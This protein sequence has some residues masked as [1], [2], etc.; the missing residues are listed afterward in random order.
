MHRK[1]IKI[2]SGGVHNICIVE[3]HPCS[4]VEEVYKQ[5][6]DCLYTDVVFQGFHSTLDLNTT[7]N[8]QIPP[9]TNNDRESSQNI[10][11]SYHSNSDEDM[12]DPNSSV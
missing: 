9:A 8:S 5:Y 2:S 11:S 1:V 4:L 3:P 6:I 7:E 12:R 10:N